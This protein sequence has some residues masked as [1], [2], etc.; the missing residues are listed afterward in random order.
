M[1]EQGGSSQHEGNSARAAPASVSHSQAETGT[2][3]QPQPPNAEEGA[4]N[5]NEPPFKK[6]L[7]REIR[8]LDAINT[9]VALGTLAVAFAALQV[10]K[11]T[12]DIKSA[13][14]NI[15]TLATQTKREADAIS[16]QFAQVKRQADALGAQVDQMKRQAIATETMARNSQSQ[17][18]AISAQTKA[19]TDSSGAQQRAAD[20]E[21][22]MADV[23]A[24]AQKPDVGI[25][26][27]RV[28]SL[29]A[30]PDKAG[31]VNGNLFWR[32]RNT[33]GSALTVIQ[34]E[35]GL[36]IGDALPRQMPKGQVFAGQDIVVTP[37]ITSAFAPKD[38]LAIM[39]DKA[40]ADL[41]VGGKTK[42]FFFAVFKYRD[43]LGTEHSRCF[44]RQ[45]VFQGGPG[46]DFHLPA[47]GSAYQCDT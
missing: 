13:V 27:L 9:L 20:A 12:S 35:F 44:G 45:F 6:S 38:P 33:G 10:A 24:Q 1:P 14:K 7:W 8:L 29:N 41:I 18:R 15:S 31:L 4:P 47:G 39:L 30:T 23:T 5:E 26:E 3:L 34:V 36:W 25:D 28:G 16:G 42:L 22:K 37:T 43:R 46:S 11:D 2:N 32:F 19:I 21:R 40:T 17:T